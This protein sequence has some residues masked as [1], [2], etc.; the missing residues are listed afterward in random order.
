MRAATW[1]DRGDLTA[2]RR[3][4]TLALAR[5]TTIDLR[6]FA[7]VE[8]GV[9]AKLRGRLGEAFAHYRAARP[10]IERAFGITSPE[11][12]AHL[13]NLAGLAHAVGEPAL[14]LRCIRAAL[15]LVPPRSLEHLAHEAVLAALLTAA[16]QHREALAL[17]RKVA[18]RLRRRGSALDRRIAARNH[19][20]ARASAT[21]RASGSSRRTAR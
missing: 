19:A 9:I 17:H 7:R 14:G 11:M 2:A 16:G 21:R 4:A 10:L 1:R 3:A 15:A 20:V 18:R 6:A 5:A 8:L 12:A 13:H